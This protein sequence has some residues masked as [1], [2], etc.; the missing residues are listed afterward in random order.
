[1]TVHQLNDPRI[2]DKDDERNDDDS[3]GVS[4]ELFLDAWPLLLLLYERMNA[5]F[6]TAHVCRVV[7]TP[8]YVK[9]H[10]PVFLSQPLRVQQCADTA[11]SRIREEPQLGTQHTLLKNAHKMHV[12]E[13]GLHVSIL[14]VDGRVQ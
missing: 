5:L 6:H 13:K 4:G 14:Q 11:D 1:M 2:A 10:S 3:E 8:V 12:H 9:V 7:H